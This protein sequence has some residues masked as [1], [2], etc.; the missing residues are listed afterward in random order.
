MSVKE[1]LTR[2]QRCEDLSFTIDPGFV[3]RRKIETILEAKGVEVIDDLMRQFPDT[4]PGELQEFRIDRVYTKVFL[5]VMRIWGTKPLQGV[6]AEGRGRIFCSV[7]QFDGC[8][9]IW[10]GIPR[11]S[12]RWIPTGSTDYEVR[13]EY[14]TNKIRSDTLKSHLADGHHLAIVGEIT[15]MAGKT[16][17]VEP[18]IMGGPW[19]PE[20]GASFDP[21]WFAYDFHENFVEDFDEFQKI[22]EEEVPADSEPMKNVSEHAFKTCLAEIIGGETPRDWGGEMSDLYS[23]HL[24]LNGR[25]ATGAFLLKGPA[26]FRPMSMAH[27]GKNNDQIY[28]LSQEPAGALIV[29]HC[30]D[31]ESAVRATL[32]AF[33]VQP[34][35]ARRYCLID[36]RDSLRLLR[37]Y[38]LMDRALELSR[39]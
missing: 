36:G 16:I 3:H 5:D 15:G 32:R 1:H 2:A 24:H 30:H 13:I 25:R 18:I 10:D 26:K 19:I 37:A 33:A 12:N 39:K 7:E 20:E 28:R 22:S 6:L 9:E 27:L 29:Q 8:P 34:G 38:G 4:L 35:N 23:A 14:S 11:A 17:T 21:S 31:I